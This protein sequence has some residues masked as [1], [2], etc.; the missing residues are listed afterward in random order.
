MDKLSK[1]H[2]SKVV[3]PAAKTSLDP[4]NAW[5]NFFNI[6]LLKHNSISLN[7]PSP[8]PLSVWKK[9]Q[10]KNPACCAASNNS[11]QAKLQSKRVFMIYRR[12][13]DRMGTRKLPPIA[14][15]L[16]EIAHT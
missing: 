14:F 3:L 2:I 8:Q 11:S 7:T 15:L 5:P 1:P 10:F 6:F 13:I 9:S 12:A 16:A 4:Q